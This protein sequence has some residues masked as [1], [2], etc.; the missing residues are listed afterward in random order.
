LISS[1]TTKAPRDSRSWA[2]TDAAGCSGNDG[3][4]SFEVA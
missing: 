2:V 1:A 3:D 4:F